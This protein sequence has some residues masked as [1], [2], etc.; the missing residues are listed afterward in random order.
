MVQ[1]AG[2]AH[3]HPEP[4]GS[5]APESVWR[6]LVPKSAVP[7]PQTPLLG[8]LGGGGRCCLSVACLNRQNKRSGGPAG[9]L[10][11]WGC[12]G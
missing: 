10:Y 6:E 11:L 9:A 3:P 8:V 5:R 1:E 4:C 7:W 12:Q 2:G